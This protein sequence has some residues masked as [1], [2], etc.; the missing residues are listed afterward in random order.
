MLKR[1]VQRTSY[2]ELCCYNGIA[3]CQG[4]QYDNTCIVPV[5]SDNMLPLDCVGLL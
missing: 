5:T 1:T 3:S 2:P 4:G